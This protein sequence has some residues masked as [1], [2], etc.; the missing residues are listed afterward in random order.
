[1]RARAARPE[2][3]PDRPRAFGPN[4]TWLAVRADDPAAVAR[5]LGLRTVLPANW[6]AGLA[7]VD[8]AGVFVAPPVDGWVLA[9]GRDLA[10]ATRD[11]DRIAALLLPISA[12]FAEAQWFATDGTDDF[13][14]WALAAR[15][16]LVRA[17]AYHG[18]VGHVLW[19]GEVTPAERGLA[20][21][22]DDP[23]DRSDDDVKWWPDRRI[24][25]ALA[26]AWSLDPDGLARPG[27]PAGSGYVGR[28]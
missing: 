26:R 20:C 10:A 5:A 28:L 1:M 15:R 18:E 22:V 17:Y 25:L 23:R 24:V 21:F 3:E 12:E 2:S 27:L 13:H 8:T 16:Q 19:H 11:P 6:S 9:V 14:G 7:E 4:A